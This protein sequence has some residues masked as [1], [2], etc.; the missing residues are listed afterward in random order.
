MISMTSERRF[1]SFWYSRVKMGRMASHSWRVC[2]CF[3]VPGMFD[4]EDGQGEKGVVQQ[5]QA[6]FDHI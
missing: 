1:P 2:G 6:A 4:A 5:H 3:R